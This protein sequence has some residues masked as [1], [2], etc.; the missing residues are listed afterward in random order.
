MPAPKRNVAGN[1][2]KAVT[3]KVAKKIKPEL[4]GTLKT[5]K[6]NVKVKPAAK[7]RGNPPNNIKA[8]ESALSSASRGGVG[9]GPLGKAKDTRVARSGNPAAKKDRKEDRKY[10]KDMKNSIDG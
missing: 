3:K 10:W 9:K 6:S 7:P 4:K 5:P 8:W 2:I 1:I